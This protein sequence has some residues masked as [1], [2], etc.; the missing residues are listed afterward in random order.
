MIQVNLKKADLVG[1]SNIT[2]YLNQYNSPRKC[3]SIYLYNSLI[4][5]FSSS[6]TI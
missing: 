6:I 4:S 3:L 2:L 1:F 5:L